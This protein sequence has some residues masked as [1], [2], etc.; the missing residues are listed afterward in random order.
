MTTH[1]PGLILPTPAHRWWWEFWKPS[2]SSTGVSNPSAPPKEENTFERLINDI[3]EHITD[4]NDYLTRGRPILH[5]SILL[6]LVVISLYIKAQRDIYKHKM[7]TSKDKHDEDVYNIY[8]S[9]MYVAWATVGVFGLYGGYCFVTY[10]S[11]IK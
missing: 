7:E 10:W 4:E 3:H 1:Q 8:N 9:C 6:G 5:I 2:T 11:E